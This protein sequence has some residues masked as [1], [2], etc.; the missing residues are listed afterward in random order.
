MSGG[1]TRVDVTFGPKSYEFLC[2]AA[3]PVRLVSTI[4]KLL[5]FPDSLH[6][7]DPDWTEEARLAF[8]FVQVHR[9]MQ[10]EPDT[11]PAQPTTDQGH[12]SSVKGRRRSSF[13]EK[14]DTEQQTPASAKRRQ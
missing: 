1:G 9:E 2:K 3:E 13:A 7:P 11:S 4:R 10:T 6:Q 12:N 14:L 8:E 5:Q